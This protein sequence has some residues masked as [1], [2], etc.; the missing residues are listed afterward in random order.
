MMSAFTYASRGDREA[1]LAASN[2]ESSNGVPCS[3]RRTSLMCR[4]LKSRA[5]CAVPLVVAA[6]NH[7]HFG[8]EQRPAFDCVALDH[9]GVAD[10]S[11]RDGE[12]RKKRHGSSLT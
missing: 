4:T 6:E 12:E 3:F 10:E 5:A 9:V 11:L 7:F 1:V 2:T 8:V